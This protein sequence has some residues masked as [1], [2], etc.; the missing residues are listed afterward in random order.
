M[1]IFK[2]TEMPQGK[3]KLLVNEKIGRQRVRVISKLN[4]APKN[5]LDLVNRQTFCLNEKTASIIN[6][7]R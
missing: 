4:V 2:Q 6:N 5:E 7:I 3:E 1:H